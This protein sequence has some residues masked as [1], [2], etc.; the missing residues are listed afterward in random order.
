MVGFNRLPDQAPISVLAM[1]VAQLRSVVVALLL[2]AAAL[3]A[4]M[5]EFI[6]A[7]AMASSS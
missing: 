7:L 6:E 1:L 2:A 3:A 5:R 4:T